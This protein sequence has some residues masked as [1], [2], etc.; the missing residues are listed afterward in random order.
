MRPTVVVLIAIGLALTAWTTATVQS[1]HYTLPPERGGVDVQYNRPY[2]HDAGNVRVMVLDG[3]D[4][5]ASAVAKLRAKGIYPVCHI[6]IGAVEGGLPDT[7]D[8]PPEVMGKQVEGRR[9]ARWLDI[10]QID[11]LAPMLTR[12]VEMCRRKGFLGVDADHL[13]V[14]RQNTGFT[15]TEE[16]QERFL[17]W[18]AQIAHEQ[19]MA[20]GL[21]NT[22]SLVLKLAR[23]FDWVLAENCFHDGW[24]E[25]LRPFRAQGKPVYVVEYADNDLDLNDLCAYA[26]QKGFTAVV[27]RRELD[28]EFRRECD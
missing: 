25:Q 22:P 3:F 13:D 14:Y 28:G 9:G 6:V 7:E 10:R 24:C 27:K 2:D 1:Y 23:D 11:M 18:F 21:K 15:L 19:G 17:R 8:F 12:R 5:S 4:T 26:R 16:D 20:V